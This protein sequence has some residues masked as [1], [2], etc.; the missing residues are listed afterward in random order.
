MPVTIAAPPPAKKTRPVASGTS[1]LPKRVE[2]NAQ[3]IHETAQVVPACLIIFRRFADAGAVS[4]ELPGLALETAKLAET[5][6]KVMEYVQRLG[7]ISPFAGFISIGMRLGMQLMVNAG[8]VEPSAMPGMG[9]VTKKTLEAQVK[10]GI[11]KAEAE[12]IQLQIDAENEKA[13]AEKL[14]AE[15]RAQNP[16]EELLDHL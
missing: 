10:A 16:D 5:N 15:I 2:E 9:L 3:R 4:R 12:A 1:S 8:R 14:W 13:A 11:A 7:T 6:P